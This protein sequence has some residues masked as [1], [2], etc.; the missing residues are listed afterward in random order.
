MASAFID[1]GEGA[2]LHHMRRLRSEGLSTREI[3]TALTVR[4]F[5]TR[6][7]N[8]LA[9]PLSPSAGRIRIPCVDSLLRRSCRGLALVTVATLSLPNDVSGQPLRAESVL[10]GTAG[11]GGMHSQT[12][13]A[14]ILDGFLLAEPIAGVGA[15]RIG[16]DDHALR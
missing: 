8:A 10:F 2:I 16:H 12:R 15:D 4:G 14:L 9:A 6:G 1:D 5:R 7:G 3:A 11:M 13:A